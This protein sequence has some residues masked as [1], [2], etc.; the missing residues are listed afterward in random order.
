MAYLKYKERKLENTI[1]WAEIGKN[2]SDMLQGE[3]KER[4]QRK[5]AINAA[6]ALDEET[7]A[8]NP[9]GTFELGNRVSNLLATAAEQQRLLDVRLL[10]T[11]Q[12]PLQQYNIKRNQMLS[13]TKELYDLVDVFQKEYKPKIEAIENG[14]GSGLM[15]W[16]MQNAQGFASFANIQPYINTNTGSI[17]L[18]KMVE[19]EKDGVKQSVISK[20]PNDVMSI[21]ML[22][23]N[24]SYMDK[25]YD[26]AKGVTDVVSRL[27]AVETATLSLGKEEGDLN[28]VLT[29]IDAKQGA[30][31]TEKG[32]IAATYK[33][34]EQKQI[35]AILENPYAA[36]S[37]LKDFVITDSKTQD[38]FDFSYLKPIEE[39][40]TREDVI[41]GYK[42]N[43][44]ILD[45]NQNGE[46]II[47]EEQRKQAEE[48]LRLNIRAAIDTK[49]SIKSAGPKQ[50]KGAVGTAADILKAKQVDFVTSFALLNYGTDEQKEF[51][52]KNIRSQ[53]SNID[54]L[55]IRDEGVDVFLTNGTSEFI[56]Y[57]D[58]NTF[59]KSGVNFVLPANAKISNFDQFVTDIDEYQKVKDNPF[60]VGKAFESKGQ[61]QVAVTFDE[62][63]KDREGGKFDVNK[64]ITDYIAL[65][66][67]K[68]TGAIN[69]SNQTEVN[70]FVDKIEDEFNIVKG[71][72]TLPENV[73]F[74]SFVTKNNKGEVTF[75][76]PG[77][78]DVKLK[79]R[80]NDAMD[81][82]TLT[83]ELDKIKESLVNYLLEQAK[84]N[85]FVLAESRDE[86]VKNY[87]QR[88]RE[89]DGGS[90]T[91]PQKAGGGPPLPG[92][93]NND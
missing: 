55:K 87:G 54:K 19:E 15:A 33:Q 63:W 73:S 36:Q 28:T 8:N 26:M 35:D 30:E 68:P 5:A 59:T 44:I 67:D 45:K 25:K 64:V 66:D 53:N 89:G 9:I 27:G 70:Q 50:G 41:K 16:K 77:Q 57:G 37:I 46:P 56:P 49:T 74:D 24:I 12:L 76:V 83:R 47:R 38:N 75:K 69:I 72:L 86:Y 10:R 18:V 2:F 65:E 79:L 51:A 13:D 20:D 17:S 11:G 21:P 6:T 84:T 90:V 42:G 61:K 31:N 34:W 3:I 32:K 43:I 48:I 1:N 40:E 91:T 52:A 93:N 29:R 14:T 23:A 80:G 39:G 62:A 88:V 92:G 58:T 81:A 22:K 7:I 78:R 60:K 82:A 4:E 71:T 85:T